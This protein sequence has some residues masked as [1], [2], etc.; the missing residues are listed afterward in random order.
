M[1]DMDFYTAGCYWDADNYVVKKTGGEV[2][3]GS[4]V[5]IYRVN[6]WY[7]LWVAGH[8]LS[9]VT[10]GGRF[11]SPYLTAGTVNYQSSSNTLT[12]NNATINV[13]A[14][15]VN[16]IKTTS[17][18]GDITI[19]T[20]GDNR[21]T[22]KTDAVDIFSNTTFT[23][24]NTGT[25]LFITSNNASGISTRGGINVTVSIPGGHL[26]AVGAQYGY[27]GSRD[28]LTLKKAIGEEMGYSFKG[29]NGAIYNVG[30]LTLDNMDF[31]TS[32]YDRGCY[33]DEA[34][35]R[36]EVNGGA[37]AKNISLLSVK[38]KL[39]IYVC[40]KQLNRVDDATYS[41]Y[42]GS[43]YISSGAESVCYVPSTKTLTLNNATMNIAGLNNEGCVK[44]RGLNADNTVTVN[45][46]GT[47]DLQGSFAGLW[48]NDCNYIIQGT[49]TLKTNHSYS[50][51]GMGLYFGCNSVTVQGNVT[52][53]DISVAGIGYNAGPKSTLTIAGN[54][55]VK[56][57]KGVSGINS[58]TLNDGQ[59]IVE[60]FKAAFNSTNHRIE[61]NGALAQNVVI[62]KVDK[63]D[64]AVCN[65]DVNSYNKDDILRDGGSFKYD[66]NIKRL[67]ITNANVDDT[68]VEEGI[69]NKGIEGLNI[70]INGENKLRFNEDVFRLSKSTTFSGSGSVKGEL[71]SSTGYGIYLAADGVIGN[72]NGPK[73]EFTGKR[74]VGDNG[75]DANLIFEKGCMIFNPIS[76][77]ASILYIKNLTLG[78]GM[79]IAEPKGG[80]FDSSK[81]GIV[82]NGSLYYGHAVITMKG[83][84]N[85]DGQV[86]IADGVAV[87]NAMAGDAIAG[88]ADVNGDGDITIADFVA[89]LNIMAN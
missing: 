19:K 87:L 7:N 77:E 46:N 65:V 32:G 5:N 53:E 36:V 73:L 88:D 6:E 74:G 62:Q 54:A 55:V 41:I 64:L 14:D 37:I 58:L 18:A 82:V 17:E 22:A 66:P 24:D 72:L 44:V 43:K 49:G 30:S 81:K 29:T 48:F 79:I 75:H 71:T 8:R 16:A 56:V 89:V 25:R 21:L 10:Q 83:D 12:L 78:D 76:S 57:A 31:Y 20:I 59:T 9:D 84:V 86:T 15:D 50:N 11:G 63:Y 47:N 40:G 69:W 27:Y 67:T 23:S 70:S 85:L 61:A 26:G 13:T 39:P 28:A 38:E 45:L 35:Y 52:I 2:V 4:T 3:K 33:F 1:E 34:D 42:V 51:S 80:T 60:P 68:S